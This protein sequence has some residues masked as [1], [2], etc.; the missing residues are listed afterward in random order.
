M[1]SRTAIEDRIKKHKNSMEKL[2]SIDRQI[3]QGRIW[4]CEAI[5][6]MDDDEYFDEG[7]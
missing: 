2:P 4:E 6:N 5:L 7:I 1:L 3:L